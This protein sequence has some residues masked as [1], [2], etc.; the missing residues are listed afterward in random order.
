MVRLVHYTTQDFLQRNPVVDHEKARKSITEACVAYLSQ[1]SFNQGPCNNDEALQYRLMKYPLLQYAARNWGNHARGSPED[2]CE[3]SIRKFLQTRHLRDSSQQ[4]SE[5]GSPKTS[6][7][8]GRSQWYRKNVSKLSTAAHFGLTRIVNMLLRDGEDVEGIDDSGSTAL[9]RAAA[10][11]RIAIINALLAAR[12]DINKL[13]LSGQSILMEAVRHGQLEAVGVLLDNGVRVNYKMRHGET[14]LGKAVSSGYTSIAMRLLE[15]GADAGVDDSRIMKAA[16]RSG[17]IEMIELIIEMIKRTGAESKNMSSILNS[18]FWESNL[19][20]EIIDLLIKKGADPAYCAKNGETLIHVA[21]K[22]GLPDIV[23]ILLKHG[24]DPNQRA[25]LGDTPLHWATF[26]GNLEAVKL[27]LSNGADPNQRNVVGDTPLHQAAFLGNLAAVKVL[28]SKGADI[29]ALNFSKESVLLSC[30]HYTSHDDIVSYLLGNGVDL[31]AIDLRG[32]TALY[33]AAYRGFGSIVQ[34]LIDH[35]APINH[36]D[37]RG[38]TAI[39]HAAASGQEGT[40][41]QLLEQA[42]TQ[43]SLSIVPLLDAARFRTAI[44]MKDHDGIQRLLR[45]PSLD[46]TVP[47]HEG[48]TALHHAAYHGDTDIVKTL[49][50]RG[51]SVHAR[52]ADSAFNYRVNSQGFD[53]ETLQWQLITPLHNT[54]CRGHVEIVQMLLDHGADVDARGSQSYKPFLFEIRKGFISYIDWL[55]DS[56]GNVSDRDDIYQMT[57]I[58]RAVLE[59]KNDVVRVLLEHGAGVE[60]DTKHGRRTLQLATRRKHT[61]IVE[62][63]IEYGFK[64]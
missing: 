59:G 43:D 20:A 30:L 26:R 19:S 13:D 31:N 57:S 40:V 50:A 35:G 46:V 53:R 24:V 9:H 45:D 63:L 37:N 33:E 51:A 64:A 47:D 48:R 32:Q 41:N 55:L 7:V 8:L 1:T 2:L 23:E 38:W 14:A 5:V 16:I 28:L 60:R 15:G 18:M 34:I 42:P 36:K 11:G 39:Q 54:A 10:N 52:I 49:L 27:L 4:A 25:A 58:S 21:A 56:R 61:E 62:L 3:E 29:A 17:K 22:R 6:I 12:A 44:A